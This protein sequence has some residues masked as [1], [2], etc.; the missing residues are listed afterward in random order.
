MLWGS[1]RGSD[2]SVVFFKGVVVY[3]FH[4]VAKATR[5]DQ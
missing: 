4:E 2:D 1:N 5:H 3:A